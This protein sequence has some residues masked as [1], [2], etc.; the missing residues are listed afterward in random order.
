MKLSILYRGAL[1]SC[2]YACHYCPFAKHQESRAEHARDAA[3]LERF[4]AWVAAQS[5]LEIGVF[6]TP[7]G[8]ALVRKRYQDAMVVLSQLEHVEKVVIQTNLSGSLTWIDRAN[9]TKIALWCTYHPMQVSRAKFLKRTSTL[10]NR[11]VRFSVGGVAM[12]EQLNELEQLRNELPKNVYLWLNAFDRRGK[13]YYDPRSLERLVAVD[14]FFEL[15]TRRYRSKGQA[16]QAGETVITV[17]EHGT[18]RR[19][20]FI[21]DAIGNLYDPDFSEILKARACTRAFCDCHIGYV[22]MPKLGLYDVFENGILERI[23][24]VWN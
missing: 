3:A 5:N 24:A 8:E 7:Y 11:G 22:H 18:V 2:N 10:L 12:T 23:P 6:F 20:H 1:S 21:D 13:N 15:N 16:C 14:P 19:C 9:L 17:D 4:V